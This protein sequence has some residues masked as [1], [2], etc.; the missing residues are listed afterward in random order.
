MEVSFKL[1]TI[2]GITANRIEPSS[3]NRLM[4]S[5]P[6]HR[7]KIM[8]LGGFEACLNGHSIGVTLTTRCERCWPISPWNGSR[9]TAG[10]FSRAAV[11]RQ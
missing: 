8:L 9:I 1:H 10:G 2:S 7:L 6:D 3:M 11:G 4:P 5:P